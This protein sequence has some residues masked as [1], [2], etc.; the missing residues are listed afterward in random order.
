M[1]RTDDIYSAVAAEVATNVDLI[2]NILRQH[3]AEGHCPGCYLS[4]R[5]PVPAPCSIRALAEMA[6]RIRGVVDTEPFP[7]QP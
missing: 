1:N 5:P 2:S 6:L 7:V 4:A 3:P